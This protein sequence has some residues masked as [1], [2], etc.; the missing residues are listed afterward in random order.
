MLGGELGLQFDE[1]GSR[2]HDRQAVESRVGHVGDRIVGEDPKTQAV[3]VEIRDAGL[4]ALVMLA[5]EILGRIGLRVEVHQKGLVAAVGAD[6]REV[7]GDTGFA[8]SA[9]LVENDA[10]H[11]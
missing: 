8:D 3:P 2:S 1:L 10:S 11:L 9:L 4:G 6:G 5:E 7:G